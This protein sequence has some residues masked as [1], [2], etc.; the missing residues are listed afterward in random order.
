MNEHERKIQT[1]IDEVGAERYAIEC[2]VVH[3]TDVER[4]RLLL[5]LPR[6]ARECVERVI[7]EAKPG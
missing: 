4:N 3:L 6:P 5:D 7:S 1:Y 2:M